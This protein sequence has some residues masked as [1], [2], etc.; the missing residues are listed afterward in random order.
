MSC[1]MM[2]AHNVGAP[3]SRSCASAISVSE[4]G[5][6]CSASAVRARLNCFG[7]SSARGLMRVS[8]IAGLDVYFLS[9][10]LDGSRAEASQYMEAARQGQEQA[11]ALRTELDSSLARQSVV[12]PLLCTQR[13][14]ANQTFRLVVCGSDEEA[15]GGHLPADTSCHATGWLLGPSVFQGLF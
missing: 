12:W 1:S 3:N 9:L 14:L 2:V 13:A 5:P 6:L 15:R 11:A 4:R 10:Q 7:P 8:L